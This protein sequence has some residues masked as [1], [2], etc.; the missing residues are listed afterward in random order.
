M[1]VRDPSER[2]DVI[3]LGLGGMGSAAARHLAARGGSVLGFEQFG[4]AHALGSS[5]GDT[6]IVRQAYFERPD[7]VPLLKRAYTLWDELAASTGRETFVRTGALMIGPARSAVV[8][9]TLASAERW[10]LPHE[11]LD[12]E[13]MARRY[14]QFRLEDGEQAVFEADAGYVDPEA[15]VRAHLELA[16]RDG[17]DLRL[18]TKVQSWNLDADGVIVATDDAE[19]RARRLVLAAGAWTSGLVPGLNVPLRV[20]RRVMHY[21][22][23]R[24][25]TAEFTADRFPVYVFETGP[26]DAIYGFPLV[27]DAAAGVKVGFHHRGPDVDPDTVDRVVSAAEED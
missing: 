7:Y 8:A 19:F 9:G 10:H 23:P 25:G 26:G 1:S 17:A 15:A 5:H 13:Q 14:P 11:L 2:A 27:G 22:A 21:L 24:S 18:K 3:V 4:P 20:G 16:A 6:R 12:R